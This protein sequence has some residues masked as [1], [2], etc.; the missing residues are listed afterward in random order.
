MSIAAA[1]ANL[2]A[3]AADLEKTYPDSN[4]SQSASV[5][6][7][8]AV[9][10][11]DVRP[12]LLVVLAGAALLLLIAGVNVASLILV[13]SE[14]RRRELA[15]RRALGASSGRLLRQFLVESIVLVSAASALGLAMALVAMQLLIWLV[16]QEVLASLPFL[17]A[18]G[19]NPRVL[20]FAA[21][22]GL[23]AIALFTLTSVS[24]AAAGSAQVALAEGGR[25]VAGTVWRRL[26]A[27]LVVAE[28]AMA[29]VLLVGAGLLGR[30]LYLLL[31]VDLGFHPDRLVALQIAA[32][33]ATYDTPEKALA[34]KRRVVERVSA[35]PG[36]RSVAVSSSLPIEG[37]GNTMWFR[38]IGRP[39]H[40]EHNE[41]PVRSV[42]AEYFATLGARMAA[43]RGF[44]AVDE[45]G[46]PA[47]AI[48]NRSMAAAYFHGEDPV[49]KQ[50][51]PL[52]TPPRPITVVGVVED[53][54][55]G[56]IDTQNRPVL[57]VAYDQAAF[58][59]MALV[60]RTTLAEVPLVRTME[61]VVRQLDADVL[62]FGG[63]SMRERIDHSPAAYIHR[64][65]AW[66][67]GVFAVLALVL[68]IVGLYAVIAYSVSRRTREIG[69]RVALGAERRRIYRMVL[70]EAGWLAAVG[71]VLG[72]AAVLGVTRFIQGLLFGVHPWDVPTLMAVALVL[73]GASL[74]ASVVPARRAASID[75]AEALRAE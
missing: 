57:Y 36:V 25:S 42:S 14:Y 62:P 75:P 54:K 74:G 44:T 46:S 33:F 52:S 16:P 24:R 71:I 7:L 8:A 70:A 37:W 5:E 72:M 28:L 35:L 21:V 56:Q 13:R 66:L 32:P 27:R 49:G 22:V 23:G 60:V 15:V 64:S 51:T 58:P 19:L 48:I 9:I 38:V 69:V 59:Y 3:I 61:T 65:L 2:V 10:V 31:Q 55:E 67:V 11:G 30:S 4:R 12:I 41:V 39:W 29:V 63:Q 18:I 20:T 17:Q 6:P 73:L 34:L 47:V 26:G 1:E 68:G 53:I 50:I 40:G 45:P 43:G